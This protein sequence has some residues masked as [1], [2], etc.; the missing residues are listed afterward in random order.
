MIRI[1][2]LRHYVTIEQVAETRSGTGAVVRTWQRVAANVP[3]AIES[4][5]GREFLSANQEQAQVDTKITIRAFPG[6][7]A[8]MRIVAA[9]GAIYNIRAILP[10]ATQRSH[11]LLMCTTGADHG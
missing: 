11:M 6:L 5:T 10:D 8:K 9:D 1:G 2:R 3:A 4:V 7:T